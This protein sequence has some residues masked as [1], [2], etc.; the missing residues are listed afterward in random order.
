MQPVDQD[1]AHKLDLEQQYFLENDKP[2]RPKFIVDFEG[3][4]EWKV[5]FD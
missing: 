5:G 3:D 4:G 1:L 2:E